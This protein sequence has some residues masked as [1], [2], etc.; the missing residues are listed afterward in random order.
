MSLFT[1][2]PSELAHLEQE[3]VQTMHETRSKYEAIMLVLAT[4]L[5]QVRQAQG[6]GAPSEQQLSD[7]LNGPITPEGPLQ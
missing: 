5:S 4:A 6:L 1:C 2:S 3:L 7:V